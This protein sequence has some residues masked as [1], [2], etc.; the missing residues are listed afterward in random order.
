MEETHLLKYLRKHIYLPHLNL[1][2]YFN[3]DDQNGDLILLNLLLRTI[4]EPHQ[5]PPL[6][7][8]LLM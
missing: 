2:L 7:N 6:S 4:L 3:P 8:N 5:I 1:L